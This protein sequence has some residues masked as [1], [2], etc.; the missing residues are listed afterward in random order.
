MKSFNS[1]ITEEVDLA[2]YV[3]SGNLDVDDPAVRD[4]IN[5]FLTGVTAKCFVTPYIAYERVS[6]VLANFH[7]HLPK[8]TFLENDSGKVVLPVSQFGGKFGMRNDGTVVTKNPDG[9]YVYF[10]YRRSDKGLYDVFCEVLDQTE[11]DEIMDDVNDEMDEYSDADNDPGSQVFSAADTRENKF[12][13]DKK[14]Y[15]EGDAIAN[16]IK[17]DQ[18]RRAMNRLVDKKAI[19]PFAPAKFGATEGS[20]ATQKV[21]KYSTSSDNL[22]KNLKEA[23]EAA[24]NILKKK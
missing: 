15:E 20:P 3:H 22:S 12:N 2:A 17:N 23:K 18:D 6:K 13:R 19:R 7:I 16:I 24:A 11:L 21:P 10:E 4:S 1:F 5:T 9:Y 14:L 8:T